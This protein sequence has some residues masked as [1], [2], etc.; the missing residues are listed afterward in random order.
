MLG[1]EFDRVGVGAP[2][3]DGLG[4]VMVCALPVRNVTTGHPEI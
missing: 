2:F 3:F 4:Q 1:S